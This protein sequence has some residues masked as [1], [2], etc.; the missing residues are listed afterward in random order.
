[1]A[2]RLLSM[3]REWADFSAT[4]AGNNPT[5]KAALTRLAQACKDVQ[6]YH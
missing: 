4:Q 6:V 2:Y 3:L 5:Y 1:M